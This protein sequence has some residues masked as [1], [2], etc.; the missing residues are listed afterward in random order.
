MN[1][2]LASRLSVL[3]LAVLVVIIVT[4]LGTHAQGTATSS[5]SVPPRVTDPAGLQGTYLGSVAAPDFRLKD[6]TGRPVSLAQFKGQPVILTFLYTHCPNQCPLTAEKLHAVMQNL[7]AAAHNVA[8]LA[9]STDPRGDTPTCALSF[10]RAHRME[11]YWHY[12]LG[13]Q[14][15]LAPV[16]SDYSVYATPTANGGTV[17]HTTAIFIIDKQ[18]RE[19]VLLDNSNSSDQI[20]TDM[21]TLLQ[22]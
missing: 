20:T 7:G 22:A 4:I 16:W 3:T 15:Q 10:S 13:T 18:G 17:N 5:S 19:R 6:Q 8:V 12:L 21:R 1:W 11:N 2:R 14:S 9:V